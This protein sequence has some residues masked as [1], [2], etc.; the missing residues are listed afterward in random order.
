MIDDSDSS[1]F[2]ALGLL[3]NG[4]VGLGLCIIAI[5]LSIIAMQNRTECGTRQC[6]SPTQ[7]AQVVDHACLCVELAIEP[8]KP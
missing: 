4:W 8:K 3:F 2:T 5:I 1:F 6:P 7:R